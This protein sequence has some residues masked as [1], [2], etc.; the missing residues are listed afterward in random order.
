MKKILLRISLVL[1]A[2]VL[3]GS[4]FILLAYAGQKTTGPL[5]S[6]FQGV[7]KN[8]V[9][10]EK[11]VIGSRKQKRAVTMPWFTEMRDDVEWLKEPDRPLL[12]AYDDMTA[13]T[14]EPI[15]LLEDAL[16]TKLPIIHFY[17]AWGSKRDQ[18]FPFLRAQAIYDL[19]SIP[20]ITWEPWLND[21]DP[22]RFPWVAGK[23][24]PNKGGMAAI[25]RGEFDEYIDQWA[26]AAMRFGHPFLLRFAHEMND[27]YRYPW[28]PQNN[29][30][31]D[32]IAAWQYVV[33]RF[34]MAG[35]T[36][37]IWVWSPHP[38]YIDY[39]AFY[40]GHEFVDWVGVT[41]LN[42]GTV[43][44]W[45]R[46]WSFHDI[47][48]YSYEWLSEYGKPMMLT[49]VSSLAVGGDR[50][51]WFREAFQALPEKYPSVKSVVFFHVHSDIT[52]SY[53]AL[54]WSFVNDTA[55]VK[56]VR[57]GIAEWRIGA[58]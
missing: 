27:P 24:D 37:T 33:E 54:D 11:R 51:Q 28:G 8:I 49:E 21:F 38:A 50:A 18:V 23:P 3:G 17:T 36:N 41:T 19:G 4:F 16:E 46:W 25:L 47:F 15:V 32:F 57:D 45:S 48:D 40:P 55:V 9:S 30:P 22:V 44:T 31:A 1:L 20:M 58:M 5:E 56:V 12:G 34:R 6:L 7:S 42:Y 10:L 29:D 2:L 43:A 52:T 39:D 13:E 26:G 53:K 35:A 14:Y